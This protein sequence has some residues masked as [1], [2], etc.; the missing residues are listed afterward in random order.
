MTTVKTSNLFPP[1][2]S[3]MVENCDDE[4]EDPAESPTVSPSCSDESTKPDP[5]YTSATHC[6]P[7]KFKKTQKKSML[8]SSKATST[9]SPS[10]KTT[11]TYTHYGFHF[12]KRLVPTMNKKFKKS[13]VNMDL[14]PRTHPLYPNHGRTKYDY[15]RAH[16]E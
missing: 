3:L 9:S 1:L 7:K 14:T 10:T 12:K 16:T 2:Y 4:D 13:G 8:K 6:I 11:S 15:N 5:Q